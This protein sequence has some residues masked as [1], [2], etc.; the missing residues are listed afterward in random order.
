MALGVCYKTDIRP[1]LYLGGAHKLK[2]GGLG[3]QGKLTSNI[4]LVFGL[5]ADP[6]IC[7]PKSLQIISLPDSNEQYVN[8]RDPIIL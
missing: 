8:N 5:D 7:Q 4:K 2:L 6:L 1:L 3:G